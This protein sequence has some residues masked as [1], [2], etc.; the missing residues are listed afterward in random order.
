M[1]KTLI[2]LLSVMVVLAFAASAFALHQVKS[3]E[4]TPGLVKSGKS[5]IEL[6]GEIR[7]RGNLSKNTD[8]NS[9][10]EDTEQKYDQRVRLRTQGNVTD[11]T[12]GLVELETGTSGSTYNWGGSSNA[13]SQQLSIR[14]AYIS[15]QFGTIGG[16]KA[17]R[18]LLALGN[19]L[20]FD[21]SNYGDDALLGWLVVGP[22]EISLIDIKVAEG[23]TKDDRTA[24]PKEFNMDD[25]DAYVLAVEMPINSIGVSADVTYLRNRDTTTYTKGLKFFNIGARVNA[26][27]QVVKVKADV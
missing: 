9:K 25:Y 18:M 26:D 1:K 6:G 5:Q 23:D 12:M 13:K 14:Q 3:S 7:I 10:A 20:F 8:F 15:H 11:K 4:Y 2:V 27:L 17:G 21:H 19:R 24:S 16:I 22:G